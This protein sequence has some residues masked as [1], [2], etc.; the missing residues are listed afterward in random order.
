[1]PFLRQWRRTGMPVLRHLLPV[2]L[3]FPPNKPE[4]GGG[5]PATYI[6]LVGPLGLH[7]PP[8]QVT[9]GNWWNLVGTVHIQQN[10]SMG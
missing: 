2:N 8:L 1:M 3:N 7:W 4:I 9:D 6:L 10:L 5:E